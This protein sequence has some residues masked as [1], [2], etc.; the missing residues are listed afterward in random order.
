MNGTKAT[1]KTIGEVE[2]ITGIPK[3]DLKYYIEQNVMRPSRKTESGYWTYS[4]EDIQRVRLTA[5]CR[6]LDLPVNAIRAILADP[7]SHWQEELKQQIIR[8]EDQLDRTEAQLRLARRLQGHEAW[9]ALQ[10]SLEEKE[11]EFAAK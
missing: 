9:E 2:H 11:A 3:R 7:A 10:L 8:L 6:S 4:D 1:G 5:L